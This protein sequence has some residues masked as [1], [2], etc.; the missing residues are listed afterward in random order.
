LEEK[1]YSMLF[2]IYAYRPSEIEGLG[3]DGR[4][5]RRYSGSS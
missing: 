3:L 4:I 2:M 5:K 1:A